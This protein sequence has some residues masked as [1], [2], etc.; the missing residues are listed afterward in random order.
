MVKNA[1]FI[2]VALLFFT[3]GLIFL[4]NSRLEKNEYDTICHSIYDEKV[5]I[6]TCYFPYNSE[7][8][9]FEMAR[10]IEVVLIIGSFAMLFFE[11]RSN[12]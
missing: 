2:F 12:V 3:Q 11:K 7:I 1:L 6:D 5:W 8:K 4:H 9:T 10:N